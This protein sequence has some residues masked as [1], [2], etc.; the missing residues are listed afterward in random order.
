MR[1]FEKYWYEYIFLGCPHNSLT[2]FTKFHLKKGTVPTVYAE[3]V[4][5]MTRLF[6]KANWFVSYMLSD[7]TT[8]MTLLLRHCACHTQKKSILIYTK[9]FAEFIQRNR[10][11]IEKNFVIT[12]LEKIYEA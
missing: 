11:E 1:E 10:S 3:S 12:D 8:V 9:D 5:F 2:F 7:D 4:P 6:V